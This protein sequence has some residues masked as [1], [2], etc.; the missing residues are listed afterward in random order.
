M[1][2]A[3]VINKG[4]TANYFLLLEYIRD[5]SVLGRLGLYPYP[6]ISVGSLPSKSCTPI[7]SAPRLRLIQSIHTPILL[8]YTYHLNLHATKSSKSTCKRVLYS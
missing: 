4:K 1:V 6:T 5:I 7:Y 2:S 8:F 3:H